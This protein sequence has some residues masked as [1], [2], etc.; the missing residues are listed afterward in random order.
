MRGATWI[1]IHTLPVRLILYKYYVKSKSI[2][3][4]YASPVITVI[5]CA[6]DQRFSCVS[7]CVGGGG[8]GGQDLCVTVKRGFCVCF[9]NFM[10]VDCQMHHN[11][12]R[13]I[14]YNA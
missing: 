7:G 4:N 5:K 8:G 1:N 3:Y 10:L 6:L 12:Y 2:P 9:I 13:T 14:Q 11:I